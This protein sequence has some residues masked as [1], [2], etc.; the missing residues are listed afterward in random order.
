M[1]HFRQPE[2]NCIFEAP[3]VCWA[4]M[5]TND[6]TH[7]ITEYWPKSSTEL[8]LQ[9]NITRVINISTGAAEIHSAVEQNLV[10]RP[11]QYEDMSSS[12]TLSRMSRLWFESEPLSV[13]YNFSPTRHIHN[14]SSWT[15]RGHC[16]I[17]K[18]QHETSY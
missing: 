4:R 17:I 8:A 5:K 18:S 3:E 2:S 1:L 11:H 16:E 10:T 7:P 6:G 9:N 12:G 13:G 15:S 14:Y